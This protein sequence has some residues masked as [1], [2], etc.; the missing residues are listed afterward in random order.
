MENIGLYQSETTTVN[1]SMEYAMI[2]LKQSN[3]TNKT[4]YFRMYF[5]EYLSDMG[6]LFLSILGFFYYVFSGYENFIQQK[7]ML[8]R[9]YRES[10]Q[11]ADECK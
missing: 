11:V 7:S 3:A 1:L 8:K 9:L 10:D 6:G 4:K 2:G 5:A